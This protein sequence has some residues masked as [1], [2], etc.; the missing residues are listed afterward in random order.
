MKLYLYILIYFSFFIF[1]TLN[2]YLEK[3]VIIFFISLTFISLPLI[4][5]IF[6]NF[7]EFLFDFFLANFM[8]YILSC[9]AILNI[10]VDHPTW[11]R[12]VASAFRFRRA[13]ARE[14]TSRT[15]EAHRAGCETV[16]VTDSLRPPDRLAQRASS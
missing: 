7:L 12:N 13:I 2:V 1:Y 5:L 15:V 8:T 10:K 16:S 11:N 4:F 6:Q 3:L 14:D 9:S